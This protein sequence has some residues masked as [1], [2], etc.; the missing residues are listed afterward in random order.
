MECWP[1]FDIFHRLR[2]YLCSKQDE[3]GFHKQPTHRRHDDEPFFHS[4]VDRSWLGMAQKWSI[5]DQKWPNMAGLST[6]QKER[7]ETKMINLSVFDHLGPFWTH[8]DPF[9]PFKQKFIFCS[10]AHPPNPTLFN[11]GKKFEIVQLCNLRHP[12]CLSIFTPTVDVKK[13]EEKNIFLWTGG[14]S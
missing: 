6:F 3:V 5:L 12:V 14:R 9:G 7:K 2:P 4:G 11:W 13:R 1:I 10:E 8:L